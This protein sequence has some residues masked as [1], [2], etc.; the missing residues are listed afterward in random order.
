MYRVNQ[1]AT[2]KIL[3]SLKAPTVKIDFDTKDLVEGHDI[4]KK[5]GP[6]GICKGIPVKP[7]EC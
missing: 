1:N 6:C 3:D 2:K 4:L 7:V 5:I